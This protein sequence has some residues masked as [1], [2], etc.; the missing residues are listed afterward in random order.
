MKQIFDKSGN[1]DWS[2][3]I[4]EI[5]EMLK[6]HGINKSADFLM[7]QIKNTMIESSSPLT[8]GQTDEL[9]ETQN[10]KEIIKIMLLK[11]MLL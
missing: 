10:V 7:K 3:N 4:G 9:F 2:V 6:I 1:F 11:T 8:N 5:K